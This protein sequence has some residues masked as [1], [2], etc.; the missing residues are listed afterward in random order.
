M[1]HNTPDPF[2]DPDFYYESYEKPPAEEG[3]DYPSSAYGV[4][5]WW[6]YG[7]W[8]TAMAHRLPHSNPHQAGAQSAA[9]FFTAQDESSANEI[10][11][12][13]DCEYV[14]IDI[15]MATPYTSLPGG[16]W[17]TGKF[18]AMAIFAGKSPSQ[19][20]EIY[21]V[22]EE[23][24]LQPVYY[25]EYYQSMCSRL[26]NFGGEEV[27]P[28]NSTWVI[29]YTERNGYKEILTH[30]RFPTYEEAK[31]YLE[32]QTSPNYRI[33]G[34]HPFVSPVPLEKLEHYQTVYESDSWGAKLDDEIVSYYVEIFEYQP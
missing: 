34:N 14:I 10:L 4:M 23:G 1:R 8:I 11:D 6:D 2:Q 33:V 20:F 17:T 26:Y 7:H 21:Y 25:P 3:Y 12:Q 29:S 19:F 5:S 16:E 31:A 30:E 27:V 13:L 18:Y 32:S 15:E 28:R 9:Q 24:M 22:P